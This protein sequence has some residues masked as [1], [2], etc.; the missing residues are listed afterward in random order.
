MSTR[1]LCAAAAIAIL[2]AGCVQRR[3]EPAPA[4]LPPPPAPPPVA[5]PPAPPPLAWEDAP[6]AA[7]DW[8][9][10]DEAG[11]SSAAFGSLF[12]LRC[13]R[14][15]EISFVR[16]GA[17]GSVLV[18]RTS[19]GARSLPASAQPDGLVA[20]VAASD[21][22]LDHIGFSRGRFAIEGEG[23]PLLILPAWPE[24]ARVIEDCRG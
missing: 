4:P 19:F 17:R 15:R 16:A 24:P 8:S 13:E 10:R 2:L 18:V 22:L 21:L 12:V 3:P 6:L 23:V 9:Y 5:P 1:S 11:A 20:R 7:G 14:S